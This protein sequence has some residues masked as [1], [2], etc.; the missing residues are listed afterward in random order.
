MRLI[1]LVTEGRIRW[2]TLRDQLLPEGGAFT[3]LLPS[4]RSGSQY[5]N[6]CD[7]LILV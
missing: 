7:L 1:L 4:A 6:H 5:P 2:V 3:S